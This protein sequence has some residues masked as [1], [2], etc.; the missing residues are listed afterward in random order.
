MSERQKCRCVPGFWF[1]PLKQEI[2]LK[3]L[4]AAGV[5]VMHPCAPECALEQAAMKCDDKLQAAQASW[6]DLCLRNPFNPCVCVSAGAG[7]SSHGA[8]RQFAGSAGVLARIALEQ[9]A[10]EREDKL[11]AAQAAASAADQQLQAL[12]A[13]VEGCVRQLHQAEERVQALQA[14][15]G[16]HAREM[17]QAQEQ[18]R[19]GPGACDGRLSPSYISPC[20]K[21]P[22]LA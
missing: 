4:K 7:A 12:Q 3:A 10:M 13:E 5:Q 19:V 15:A 21:S 14:E 2:A 22:V 11:Q 20:Y 18:V 16:G 9:A 6:Q 17:Q 1:I 8:R